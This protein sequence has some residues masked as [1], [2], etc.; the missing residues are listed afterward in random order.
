MPLAA[1]VIPPF[2][3][4]S[5]EQGARINMP[6]SFYSVAN[7]HTSLAL[8]HT[9]AGLYRSAY[10]TIKNFRFLARLRLR[11]ILC[12]TPGDSRALSCNLLL[13]SL[14]HDFVLLLEQPVPELL[15][16]CLT[17]WLEI[18]CSQPLILL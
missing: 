12:L 9:W 7:R 16:V 2:R 1:P 18:T 10:P 17:S 8:F 15:N 6:G 14:S 4:A 5:V 3:F 11:C 13:F